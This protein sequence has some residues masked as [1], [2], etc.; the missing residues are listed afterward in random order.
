MCPRAGDRDK[1]RGK[2]GDV[3]VDLGAENEKVC[4]PL[5]VEDPGAR[6]ACVAPEAE[7][8]ASEPEGSKTPQ[9][10]IITSSEVS[11]DLDPTA[12]IALTTEN[13]SITWPKTTCLPAETTKFESLSRAPGA[14]EAKH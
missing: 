13:P 2:A 5:F 9:S 1:L 4:N 3:N 11:P 8:P 7:A 14:A 6:S 12:S 10:A